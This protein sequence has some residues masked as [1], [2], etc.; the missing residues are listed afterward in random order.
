MP[1]VLFCGATAVTTMALL[2]AMSNGSLSGARVS[3]PSA[4][5]S[6]TI[7]LAGAK[8]PT[9]GFAEVVTTTSGPA[10]KSLPFA[11]T[12]LLIGESPPLPPQPL[13]SPKIVA[14]ST[15]K[16]IA[17]RIPDPSLISGTLQ[18]GGLSPRAGHGTRE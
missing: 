14:A 12:Y 16:Q 1:T 9:G 10:P 6:V 8:Y 18:G 2:S 4:T 15:A 13:K 3:V 17:F 7:P 11:Y 5:S